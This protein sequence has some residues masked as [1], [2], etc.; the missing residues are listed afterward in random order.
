[1]TTDIKCPS[2]GTLFGKEREADD[3]TSL[4]IKY[5]DLFRTFT[6]GVVSGPCRGCATIVRWKSH[7]VTK[8]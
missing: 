8:R 3:W 2:C 4:T 6:H 5:R 1:M 7:K